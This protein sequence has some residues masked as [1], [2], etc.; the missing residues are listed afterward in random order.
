MTPPLVGEFHKL[1][2]DAFFESRIKVWKK[3]KGQRLVYF[4][5]DYPNPRDAEIRLK[6]LKAWESELDELASKYEY[7]ET[8]A[9]HMPRFIE[10]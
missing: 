7:I 1:D 10:I 3:H 4:I 8:Y 9:R 6:V 5:V 2:V